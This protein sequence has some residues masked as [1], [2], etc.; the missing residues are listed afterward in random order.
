MTRQHRK[1]PP[2]FNPLFGKAAIEERIRALAEA[3]SP[4]AQEAIEVHNEQ[5]LA[6][7]ILRG[8]IFFFSDLLKHIPHPV[9]PAFCHCTSYSSE[10]NLSPK[11]SV[12]IDFVSAKFTG[13]RVLLVDDIC[14]TGRTLHAV[15][16][17][18]MASD[19]HEVKSVV[20]VLREVENPQF[21]PD[22]HAFTYAGKEWLSGYGME[23]KNHYSNYPDIYTL[24]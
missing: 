11:A 5:V 20:T 15:K 24:S 13:R 16:E 1:I 4:W 3:I 19:A 8:G 14:D 21:T 23:D 22:W 12:T 18:C 6:L 7:C 10:A 9:E 2:H 17:H